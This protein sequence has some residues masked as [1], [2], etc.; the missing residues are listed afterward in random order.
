MKLKPT[1]GQMLL[2][3]VAAIQLTVVGAYV[4]AAVSNGVDDH[5][6]LPYWANFLFLNGYADL[7]LLL[8]WLMLSSGGSKGKFNKAIPFKILRK[9]NI[10]NFK[11]SSRALILFPIVLIVS[12]TAFA[13]DAT[14]PDNGRMEMVEAFTTA[15]AAIEPEVGQQS[16]LAATML[17]RKCNAFPTVNMIRY[18]LIHPNSTSPVLTSTPI[19]KTRVDLLASA[20]NEV[21]CE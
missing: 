8:V 3:T 18:V 4:F 6:M 12:G 2:F 19:Q 14:H 11:I 13:Q 9:A 16:M 15:L 7:L 20:V 1:P 21:A 17:T 10:M 5:E